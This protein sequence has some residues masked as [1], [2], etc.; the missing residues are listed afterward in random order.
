[1][2][3]PV[4][5]LVVVDDFRD[6]QLARTGARGARVVGELLAEGLNQAL[7]EEAFA[8]RKGA[9]LPVG[10]RPRPRERV[11]DVAGAPVSRLQ[12]LEVLGDL[13]RAHL[14]GPALPA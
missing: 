11:V 1:V 9:L 5:A 4:R 7:D 2:R 3:E 8:G 6:D 10:D 13:A 12:S 14:A